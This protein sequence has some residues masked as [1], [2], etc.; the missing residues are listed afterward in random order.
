ME[1]KGNEEDK[2]GWGGGGGGQGK[3]RRKRTKE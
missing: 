2:L 3:W 1:K